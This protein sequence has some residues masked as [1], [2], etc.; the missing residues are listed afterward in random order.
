M[1]NNAPEIEIISFTPAYARQ[2]CT[3]WIPLVLC[4]IALVAICFAPAYLGTIINICGT[5]IL[6]A[7]MVAVAGI[8]GL[9]GYLTPTPAYDTYVV[10]ANNETLDS[11]RHDFEMTYNKR[12]GTW[13]LERVN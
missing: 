12:N 3:V 5:W 4:V 2:K 10:R 9:A 11:Y 13:R 6:W 7:W 8:I 1:F